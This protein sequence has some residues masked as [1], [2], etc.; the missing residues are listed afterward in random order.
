MSTTQITTE[1]IPATTADPAP[2][3]SGPDLGAVKAKQRT[4]WQ[5]GDYPR[6]GNTLQPIA[7]RLVGAAAVH[8]GERVLDLACGQGNAALAAARRFALAT[9]VDY[10]PNLLEQGRA[11]AAAEQLPVRFT[12]GDAEALPCDDGDWDVVLSTVGVMFAPDQQRA[13]DEVVR[14]TR[15]GGRIGLASWTPD[16]LV[17]AMFA[18]NGR[19]APPPAGLVSP[20]RWGTPERLA[21]LF[22]DRV[23]W[24]SL[25]IRTF[26]F[27]FRDAEHFAATFLDHYGPITTLAAGLDEPTRDRFAADLAEVATRFDVSTDATLVA[28]SRYL[29]AVGVRR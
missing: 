20:M 27:C 12:E 17:G 7:E 1:T 28:S 10:A 13:A 5:S 23:V 22:G 18:V 21:E 2:Q 29:E 6:V 11:R 25:R 14:V 15:P 26:D 4:A 9:G 3:P 24:T 16:S 19:Y 8:A